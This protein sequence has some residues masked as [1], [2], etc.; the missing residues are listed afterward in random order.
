M[1]VFFI[2]MSIHGSPS[3][4]KLSSIETFAN[5][6]LVEDLPIKDHPCWRL[7]LKTLCRI[8]LMN[9]ISEGHFFLSPKTPYLV[10]RNVAIITSRCCYC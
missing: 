5:E 2:K 3:S 10:I 9:Q 7:A 1:N 6:N 8:H 4:L